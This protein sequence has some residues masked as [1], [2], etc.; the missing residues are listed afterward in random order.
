MRHSVRT[1]SARFPVRRFLLSLGP[2]ILCMSLSG[3]IQ[4]TVRVTVFPDGSGSIALDLGYDTRKWPGIFGDPYEGFRTQDQMRRFVDPG[5]T[6]WS[7]PA[8]EK[9]G[10]LRSWRGEVFFD[11][12]AQLRFLGRHE[13]EV[14]E[15]LGFDS[16]PEQGVL[17]LRPGF[18]VYLDD[19]LPL[20]APERVGM[21]GVNLSPQL[22]DTIRQ[23]IRPV[24]GGLDVKLEVELPGSIV[25]ADGMDSFDGR[26]ATLAVDADR[27][28]AAFGRR[29]GVLLD[30][31]AIRRDRPAWAWRVPATWND[32]RAREYRRRRAEALTWWHAH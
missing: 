5:M 17:G 31:E 15:A 24:I 8:I 4:G 22:L 23:R 27:L 20:P 30:E 32:A 11:D 13:G 25:R 18:V 28:A 10:R 3:C 12:I 9:N 19:P 26:I 1:S 16:A 14:I 2:W 6:A 7:Q 21:S 29:A